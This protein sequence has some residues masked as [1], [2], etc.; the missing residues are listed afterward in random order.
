MKR[1]GWLLL[2]CTTFIL[3]AQEQFNFKADNYAGI[4]GVLLDPT[5]NLSNP[6]NW[7]VNIIGVDA[8]AQNNYSYISD[9]SLLSLLIKGD[10]EVAEPIN[11]ITG[12]TRK[13]TW[14]FYSTSEDKDAYVQVDVLG[15][16]GSM[17]INYHNTI[18]LFT[19]ARVVASAR[20]IDS[21]FNYYN[22][23]E[24]NFG[25]PFTADKSDLQGAAWAEIGLNYA[26]VL[27]DSKEYKFSTGVNLKYL[28][29]TDAAYAVNHRRVGAVAEQDTIVFN[30]LDVEVGVVTG[31]EMYDEATAGEYSLKKNGSGLAMDLGFTFEK[32]KYPT[33]IL[34]DTDVTYKWKLNASILDIGRIKYKNAEVH[35]YTLDGEQLI[36]FE[37]A[38]D[39]ET[40][41]QYFQDLS[42][43]VYGD[44]IQSKIGNDFII[45]LPTALNLNFDYGLSDRWYVKTNIVQR[46][47]V[48]ENSLKRSNVVNVNGRYQKNWFGISGGITAYEYQNVYLGGSLRMGPLTIGSDNFIPIAVPIKEMK[49][50]DFYFALKINSFWDDLWKRHKR[51]CCPR[52]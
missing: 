15:P 1:V 8:F 43:Q 19:R 11:G 2:L 52:F 28:I 51:R 30:N 50:A 12:A 45:G 44:S 37:Q 22:F 31:S 32:K 13:R 46:V 29:G 49:G 26:K 18:G 42:M 34:I 24:I 39:T 40:I 27:K 17:R 23:N 10:L 6:N 47:P 41:E 35:R 21:G 4:N 38:G 48:F 25:T 5:H 36:D 7:D 9:A 14:D 33:D 16:S 20:N 3:K